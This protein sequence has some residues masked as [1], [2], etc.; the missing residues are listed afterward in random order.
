[1]GDIPNSTEKSAHWDD[2][3]AA[4]MKRRGDTGPECSSE[5]GPQRGVREEKRVGI[6]W[7]EIPC[8]LDLQLF[9]LPLY[10]IHL[11]IIMGS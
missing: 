9:K 8:G 10:L 3:G 5:G 11:L 7:L 4:T 6:L 2:K 1:M